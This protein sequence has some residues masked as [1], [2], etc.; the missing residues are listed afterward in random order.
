MCEDGRGLQSPEAR[1]PDPDENHEMGSLSKDCRG[2][3]EGRGWGLSGLT[4][5]HYAPFLELSSFWVKG[6]KSKCVSMRCL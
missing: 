3:P 2:K 5:C 1:A 6:G 4:S